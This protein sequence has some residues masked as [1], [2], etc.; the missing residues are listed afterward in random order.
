[1]NRPTLFLL[2]SLFGSTLTAQ[3]SSPASTPSAACCVAEIEA[4]SGV[5]GELLRKGDYVA[6]E[7][8]AARDLST[9][10]RFPGGVWK[11]HAFYSGLKEPT[12]GNWEAHLQRL[13]TW[14]A[15][16][17][18]SVTA[19]VAL[20]EA[21][22]GYGWEARGD[23]Y[24]DKVSEEGWKKL[25]E[26]SRAA[27]QELK[28]TAELNPQD[29]HYF[30]SLLGVAQVR[31]WDAEMARRIV[32]RAMK[33]EPSYYYTYRMYAMYMLPKWYGE[34]GDSER[35]AEEI[36]DQIG[37]KVGDAM[38]AEIAP[39][40]YC[41]CKSDTEVHMSMDRIVRGYAADEELY[42]VSLEKINKLAYIA[43]ST[44]S[45]DVAKKAFDRLG[46]NW[47]TETWRRKDRYDA[48]KAWV[49]SIKPVIA[50]GR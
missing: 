9:K 37:G 5:A 11:L 49:G 40:L 36:A 38:Y 50:Q 26:R 21:Y 29:P 27:L 48:Y 12:D 47:D 43:V 23:T 13:R 44:K 22:L 33:V 15:A 2:L 31:G 7:Q 3:Q 35:F 18:T 14:K 25:D 17:P 42:G 32:D 6:L 19:R 1:M 4:Y 8:Q 20:A 24:A 16:K 46:N 10:A 39:A 45:L 30:E 41:Q 34:P 28:D